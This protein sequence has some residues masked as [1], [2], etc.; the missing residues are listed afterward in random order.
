MTNIKTM[1]E[2]EIQASENFRKQN[3]GLLVGD[4]FRE[5]TQEI[6]NS[7]KVT[8]LLFVSL[9]MGALG[10]KEIADAMK[11]QQDQLKPDLGQ[12]VKDNLNIFQTP[13][14]M[15]YW[16]IQIGRKLQQEETQA[17]RDLG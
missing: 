5:I 12:I 8:G 15:L 2:A 4:G 14:E 6:L 9:M 17:L 7:Q 10:G 16:G 1:L 11:K 3:F 13:L